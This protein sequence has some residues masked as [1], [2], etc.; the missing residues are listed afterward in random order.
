MQL[1]WIDMVSALQAPIS[2]GFW[3]PNYLQSG[4]CCFKNGESDL[5]QGPV[6]VDLIMGVHTDLELSH[7][8]FPHKDHFG[9]VG[10]Q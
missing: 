6:Q 7:L 10:Q 1:L 2:R 8:G 5:P 4:S 3:T 9:F